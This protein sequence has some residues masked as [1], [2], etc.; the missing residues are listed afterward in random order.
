MGQWKDSLAVLV[1]K[2]KKESL[3][4]ESSLFSASFVTSF[5]GFQSIL[6]L[7]HVATTISSDIYSFINV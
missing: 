2:L 6:H 4:S 7:H 5:P 3:V 1:K